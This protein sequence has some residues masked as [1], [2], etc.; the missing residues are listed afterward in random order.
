MRGS[1]PRPWAC[2]Q[3]SR[4][5]PLGDPPGPARP[6]WGAGAGAPSRPVSFRLWGPLRKVDEGGRWP[7]H[8]ASWREVGGHGAPPSCHPVPSRPASPR[9]PGPLSSS[10]PKG[11]GRGPEPGVRGGPPGVTGTVPSEGLWD[12][13]G[14]NPARARVLRTL[15]VA[16][17]RLPLARRGVRGMT[18]PVGRGYRAPR[19]NE[20]TCRARCGTPAGVQLTPGVRVLYAIFLDSARVTH[21]P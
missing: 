1:G 20:N 2:S 7:E 3:E 13:G 8:G 17:N 10:A 4:T 14:L 21:F 6:P 15:P 9:L 16:E 19:S 11:P 5:N 18:G 12:R